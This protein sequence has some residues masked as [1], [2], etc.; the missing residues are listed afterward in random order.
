[1]IKR[2]EIRKAPAYVVFEN[3]K[4]FVFVVNANPVDGTPRRVGYQWPI[5][6]TLVLDEKTAVLDY[7]ISLWQ[8]KQLH[9]FELNGREQELSQREV[10]K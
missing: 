10:L 7:I 9:L 8:S 4:R 6:I 3:E 2:A 1:M 5:V